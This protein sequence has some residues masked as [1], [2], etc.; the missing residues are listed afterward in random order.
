MSS[1]AIIVIKN[2]LLNLIM[3]L[4][5]RKLY[6]IIYKMSYHIE[7]T[8]YMKVLF[9]L[10]V[11]PAFLLMIY[12]RRKDKIEKEPK[13]LIV[14]L[15]V[16]GSVSV[17]PAAF[18]EVIID[19]FAKEIVEEGSFAYA[20]IE[21][22]IMAALTEECGKFVMLKLRTWKNKEF[23]Y[24]FDAVVYAVAVSLGFATLENILYV[25]G[26]SIGVAIMRGI[27][28]VP[29]HAIDAVFMGYYYGLA[30]RCEFLS[31]NSG[32]RKNLLKALFSA[33]LIHGFYDFC[34]MVGRDEF[35]AI[36]FIFEIIIFIVTVK[37]VNKLSREDS[38]IGPPMGVGFNQYGNYFM[39]NP[40]YY[41]PNGYYR[42]YDNFDPN[43]YRTQNGYSGYYQQQTYQQPVYQQTTY[44]QNYANNQ[45]QY[46]G[47]SATDYQQQ[48]GYT[49]NS[50]YQNYGQQ[51]GYN[52][53]NYNNYYQQNGYNTNQ[54]YTGYTQNTQNGGYNTQNGY[55]NGANNSSNSYSNY[56]SSYYAPK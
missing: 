38:P 27:L 22:F 31:D 16:L 51:N 44:Q 41:D 7:R 49:Y 8:G 15:F 17:I 19:D 43:L 55:Y 25:M 47:T 14:S 46:N 30:K 32:K 33:V 12:I 36:F 52:N 3:L 23:N 37:K 18:I 1:E 48:Q 29:G 2:N 35:I 50:G 11:L 53:Y 42:Q 34:L 10:A 20:A 28:S 5:K 56:N 13:G 40:Y 21:A 39:Q 6:V 4:H 24:T 54:Q 26:G 45:Y 9:G